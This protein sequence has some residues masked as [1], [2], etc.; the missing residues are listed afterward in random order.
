MKICTRK[1]LNL[2]LP[3]GAKETEGFESYTTSETPNQYIYD[4]F[5]MIYFFVVVAVFH[6][7][8]LQRSQLDIHK[9]SN[10]VVFKT[11]R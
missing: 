6:F 9:G 8:A 7:L 11:I 2:L 10:A 1:V 4:A 5:L 3:F